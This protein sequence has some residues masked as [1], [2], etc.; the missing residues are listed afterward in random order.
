MRV[1]VVLRLLLAH[2]A[3]GL[4]LVGMVACSDSSGEPPPGCPGAPSVT[5]PS[6]PPT[7]TADIQPLLQSRCYGCHGPGGIEQGSFDLTTYNRVTG[8]R[9]DIAT[10]VGQCIMPPPDA[11]QLT[12]QERTELFQWIECGSPN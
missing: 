2:A 5:C 8:A 11:G 1:S 3:A 6:M 4:A 7:Y 12:T 10:Q 9:S